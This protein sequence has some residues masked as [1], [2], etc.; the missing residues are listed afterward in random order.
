MQDETKKII[1]LN[2]FVKKNVLF[3]CL[4]ARGTGCSSNMCTLPCGVRSRKRQSFIIFRVFLIFCRNVSSLFFMLVLITTLWYLLEE[5]CS[6]LI[7]MQ[8]Q[9]NRRRR[10]TIYH[11]TNKD[12]N[13]LENMHANILTNTLTNIC[14]NTHITSTQNTLINI[15]TNTHINTRPPK[16][17]TH[18]DSLLC[19][20]SPFSRL[21][22]AVICLYVC[23]FIDSCTCLFVCLSVCLCLCLCLCLSLCLS[24]SLSLSLSLSLSKL[25]H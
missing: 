8:L 3:V 14:K 12:T 13:T 9:V 21:L 4:F 11:I 1:I 10:N 6:F 20:S 2:F 25:E 19:P 17:K 5:I 16:K 7:Y 18:L 15:H 23:L 24:V 22:S